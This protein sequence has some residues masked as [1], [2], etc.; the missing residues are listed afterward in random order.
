MSAFVGSQTEAF[1]GQKHC[2]YD[3]DKWEVFLERRLR[4]ETKSLIF[5]FDL[6]KQLVMRVRSLFL[7]G[8]V[9]LM[10]PSRGAFADSPVIFEVVQ[11]FDYPGATGVTV[12]S[13]INDN[14]E[15][16]GWFISDGGQH[17]FVRF[18]NRFS[19]AIS[20]P[21][22]RWESTV[23]TGVNN[24]ATLCGSYVELTVLTTSSFLRVLT[25][26]DLDTGISDLL[27]GGINDANNICGSTLDPYKALVVVNGV[28]NTFSIPGAGVTQGADR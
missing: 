20:D 9:A 14:N 19:G 18:G 12:A 23:V 7:L 26:T 6:T 22:D 16:A 2:V 11:T 28:A 5:R 4:S 24:A 17:G 10:I 21:N 1:D 13:A 25:F 15:V 3:A 8:A 27:S